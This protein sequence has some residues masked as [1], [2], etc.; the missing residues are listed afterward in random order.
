MYDY[1]SSRK[2]RDRGTGPSWLGVVSY[3]TGVHIVSDGSN[4][5]VYSVCIRIHVYGYNLN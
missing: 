4:I 3:E 2:L 1:E 5:F